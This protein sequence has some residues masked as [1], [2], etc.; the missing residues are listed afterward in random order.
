[1][2]ADGEEISRTF[3]ADVGAPFHIIINFLTRAKG[4]IAAVN[5]AYDDV[6]FAILLGDEL[7]RS[8]RLK[9]KAVCARVSDIIDEL[10]EIA[11]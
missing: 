6:G 8:A 4:E 11:V 7:E 9:D 1:M 2:I 5:V 10:R 3:F